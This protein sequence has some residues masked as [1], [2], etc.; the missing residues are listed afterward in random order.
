MNE[1]KKGQAL[2]LT[3]LATVAIIVVGAV[4]FSSKN[5]AAD[6]GNNTFPAIHQYFWSETCPHCANV[7]KFME[8]WEGK[9]KLEIEKYEINQNSDFRSKFYSA[10]I[11]CKIS[12][13][14]LSVPLLV[15]PHG[16]CFNGDV[17]IIEYFEKMEFEN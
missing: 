11:L 7:A 3:I 4:I 2:L 14:E 15:T 12:Q 16:E 17:P 6:K 5:S 10:G 13:T 1:F 9:D 8:S